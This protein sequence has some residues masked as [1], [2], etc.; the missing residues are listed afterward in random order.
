MACVFD[1]EH[2]TDEEAELRKQLAEAKAALETARARSAEEASGDGDGDGGGGGSAGDSRA[3][4]I[5]VSLGAAGVIGMAVAA[6]LAYRQG[7]KKGA[8]LTND[9]SDF[10][11]NASFK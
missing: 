8:I 2:H 3:L 11:G 6:L 7:K 4:T 10:N 9:T 5:G 1:V